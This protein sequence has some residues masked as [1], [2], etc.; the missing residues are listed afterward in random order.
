MIDFLHI[1]QPL[2]DLFLINAGF[3]LSQYIVLRAG[4]FSIATVGLVAIGAYVGAILM[5]RYGV[6]IWVAAPASMLGGMGVGLVLSVPLARLRGPYQAIATLAFVQIVASVALYAES[7]TGGAA[8]LGN[9][10]KQVSTTGLVLC[11]AAAVYVLL[12][13]NRTRLGRIYDA[14][15]Q[16]ETVA[17]SFGIRVSVYH[18]LAFALSGA[19][20]GLFGALQAGYIYSIAPQQYGFGLLATTLAAVIL[21]GRRAV[22]GPLI[23]AAMMTFLPEISRPLAEHR[24]MAVGGLLVVVVI[25]MPR[26][27]YEG[28]A[29]LLRRSHAPAG[30]VAGAPKLKDDAAA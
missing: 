21:G 10:P 11:L 9:I 13:L 26:G 29:A 27:I 3:A 15:S 23:G 8:G 6:G 19:I 16:D 7:L 30:Q 2:L 28:V 17:G 14:L 18:A 5:T 20:A 25:F 4:V 22:W 1:Y 12:C 24:L